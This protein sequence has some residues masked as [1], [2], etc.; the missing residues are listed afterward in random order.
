[1][2]L[3]D[4]EHVREAGQGGILFRFTGDRRD[5][6]QGGLCPRENLF[7]FANGGILSTCCLPT[8]FFNIS[9]KKNVFVSWENLKHPHFLQVP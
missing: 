1:M 5:F 3:S 6:V 4:A 7:T 2:K 8:P 9:E